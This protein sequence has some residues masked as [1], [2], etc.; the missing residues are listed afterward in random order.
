M[1][2]VLKISEAASLALHAMAF[3][4]THRDRR[5]STH[6][7]ATRLHASEAHLSKVLQ[8]LAK[9][10]LVQSA[11]GPKGGFGLADHWQ[12]IRLLDVY[13]A[14]EGRLVPAK[15]L[16]GTP[17]CGGKCIFG[18]LVEKLNREVRDRL[19]G[20]RLSDLGDIFAGGKDGAK[21]DYQ[22]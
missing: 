4:S 3:L 22:D 11:R 7:I 9:A 6:E 21:E 5:S 10:G 13:E 16:L 14:I 20:T 1:D 19:A 15:C 17:I 12:D 18:G 8:R 2:N